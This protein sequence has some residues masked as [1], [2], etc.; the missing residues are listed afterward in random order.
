MQENKLSNYLHLHFIVFI[1]GFTAVLGKLISIEAIPLVLYRL[2][3]ASMFLFGYLLIKKIR[4]KISTKQLLYYFIGGIIIA[5]HWIAF[6]YA[7]KIS[8]VSITL[9]TLATGAFF[10]SVLEPLF[11]KTKIKAYEIILS[12]LTFIGIAIIF[13]VESEFSLGI[14]I[15]LIAAFLSAL[16]TVIN[17]DFI[18]ENDASV[19]SFYEL[20][21]A[22][23]FMTVVALFQSDFDLS[24]FNI[25]EQ[26]WIYIFILGSI[27]TAYA[28]TASTKLLK[29]IS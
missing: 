13:K 6:F 4:L 16:F 15:A 26:D 11:F 8:N 1:W 7:I 23:F 3:I 17:A 25:P 27:C 21:F 18:K 9:A 22:T 12:V 20:L 14:I 24:Y 2:A 5:I 29:K 10:A 19:I 28:L